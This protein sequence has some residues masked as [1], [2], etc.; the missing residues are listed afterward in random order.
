VDS[1]KY[2]LLRKTT[3]GNTTRGK[4]KTLGVIAMATEKSKLIFWL[5]VGMLTLF[6]TVLCSLGLD[7]FGQFLFGSRHF[8]SHGGALIFLL[9]ILSIAVVTGFY[10]RHGWSA[11]TRTM[12]TLSCLSHTA[13]K[14]LSVPIEVRIPRSFWSGMAIMLDVMALAIWAM[15]TFVPSVSGTEKYA[16]DGAAF[17]ALFSLGFWYGWLTRAGLIA[18]INAEGVKADNVGPK[19]SLRW[20]EITS[21]EIETARSVFGERWYTRITFRAGNDTTLMRLGLTMVNPEEVD[22]FLVGL[23]IAFS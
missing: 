13:P 4:G 20:R 10:R 5:G 23:R 17:L 1:I 19:T 22:R 15:V 11:E 7:V 6:L 2:G 3:V 18:L 16:Y 21:C 12:E 14:Y 8:G 9:L